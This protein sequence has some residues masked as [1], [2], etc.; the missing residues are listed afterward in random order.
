MSAPVEVDESVSEKFLALSEM[1]R[2]DGFLTPASV[3]DEASDPSSVLHDAF[4]WDDA[5]A[6][7]RYRL[8][9]AREL[10]KTYRVKVVSSS[11]NEV[12]S[13]RAFVHEKATGSYAPVADVVADPVRRAAQSERLKVEIAGWRQRAKSFDEFAAV[14]DAIDHNV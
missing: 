6:G 11:S 5:V 1:Y 9:Q 14:V 4:E 10:I 13:V 7:D 2:R 8:Q 3:K 12:V